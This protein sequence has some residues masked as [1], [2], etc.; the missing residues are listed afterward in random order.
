[1]IH[2]KIKAYLNDVLKG[3]F[4][5]KMTEKNFKSQILLRFE[6]EFS[7]KDLNSIMQSLWSDSKSV[8]ISYFSSSG[9]LCKEILEK[10][11]KLSGLQNYIFFSSIRVWTLIEIIE[12][13][14]K[15][16]KITEL[17]IFVFYVSKQL[18]IETDKKYFDQIDESDCNKLI[19]RFT[20]FS[21]K[22][23]LISLWLNCIE[24]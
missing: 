16:D 2:Q 12:D 14:D 9:Y 1:M 4:E 5:G 11:M 19:M 24:V 20:S 21:E 8:D 13:S 3:P 15:K 7:L 22:L 17:K 18:G 10:K 6:K 23:D